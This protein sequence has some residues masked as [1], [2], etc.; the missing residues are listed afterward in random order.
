MCFF[1]SKLFIFGCAATLAVSALGA[2]EI[3]KTA[4]VDMSEVFKNYYKTAQYQKAL[5]RQEE[6]FKKKA[7]E[8]GSKI[9]DLKKKRNNLEDKS[10]NVAL[11][12]E[13]RNQHKQEAQAVEKRYQAKQQQLRKYLQNKQQ[14]LRKRY[15]DKRKN[16]VDEI[17]EYIRSYADKNNIQLVFDVSGLTNNLLPAILH[18][19]ES[20]EITQ[21][22]LEQI[23]EGHEKPETPADVGAP[24]I[25]ESVE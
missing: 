8:M 4:Y 7:E 15:M 10:L 22:I 13:V 12:E 20:K 16:I 19:P 23:N 3:G 14:E 25:K 9:K 1:R 5:K 6:V 18:Y 21:K 17:T 2:E 24:E 11:S